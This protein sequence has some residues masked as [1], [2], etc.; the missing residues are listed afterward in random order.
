VRDEERSKMKQWH[1]EQFGS[2]E[3]VLKLQSVDLPAPW[4]GHVAIKVKAAGLSLPD[5]LMIRGE[6]PIVPAPPLTPGIGLREKSL[7]LVTVPPS[8]SATGSWREHPT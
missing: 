2:P 1:L 7:P 8:M 6:H 5:L 3:K 4:P